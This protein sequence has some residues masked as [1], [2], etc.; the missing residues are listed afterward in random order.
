MTCLVYKIKPSLLCSI[1]R[2]YTLIV[3]CIVDHKQQL[4]WPYYYHTG[5]PHDSSCFKETRVYEKLNE[6]REALF[7]KC[8]F[9]L[10]DSACALY[11]FI[12]PPFVSHPSRSQ[13]D[14][15]GAYQSSARITVYC[16]F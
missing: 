3:Q 11:S 4:L 8:Y 12:I 7:L 15:F 14:N 5:D 9:I 1:N 13:E 16:L 6:I 10:S 2:I